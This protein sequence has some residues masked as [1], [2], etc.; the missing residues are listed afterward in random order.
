LPTKTTQYL[1]KPR[2]M[3]ISNTEGFH[4]QLFNQPDVES[5]TKKMFCPSTSSPD[6]TIKC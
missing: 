3:I 4:I 5:L 6:L 1:T 2:C